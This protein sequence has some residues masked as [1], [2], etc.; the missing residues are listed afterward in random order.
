MNPGSS[1]QLVLTATGVC[2]EVTHISVWEEAECSGYDSPE[3]WET[4]ALRPRPR[5][6]RHRRRTSSAGTTVFEDAVAMMADA[7]DLPLD[8]V[9]YVPEVALATKDLDLGFMFIAKGHVAGLQQPL[10]RHRRTASRSSSS[11]R[12]GR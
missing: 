7:L 9:R 8:E 12:S 2:S 3:L 6:A 5:R 11:A 1:N 4:V 10:A